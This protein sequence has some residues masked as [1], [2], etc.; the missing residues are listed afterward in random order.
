MI[1]LILIFLSIWTFQV[2]TSQTFD[3]SVQI[4]GLE[5]NSGKCILY[6]YKDKKGF[7]NNAN[8]AISTITVSIKDGK[9][10]GIFQGLSSGGYAVS[11]VHD[12]NGNGKLDNN[13]LGIPKEGIGTS[14]N[15]KSS[16]GPP[17]FEDARFNITTKSN[18]I[19]ITIKY[20]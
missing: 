18:S 2:E 19:N 12:E 14:N 1:K 17:S 3:C 15:P 13:F 8:K 7:P 11:V 6:L 4:S 5:S 10:I 9:A 16:F 20:L